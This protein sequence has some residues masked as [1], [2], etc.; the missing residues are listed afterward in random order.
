M[1]IPRNKTI[2]KI[3][4]Q[5]CINNLRKSGLPDEM[6]GFLLKSLHFHTPCYCSMQRPS[7]SGHG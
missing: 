6:L 7:G 5:D 3:L 1:N 2:R 4:V